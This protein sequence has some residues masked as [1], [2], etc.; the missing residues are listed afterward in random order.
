AGRHPIGCPQCPQPPS[1]GG[2]RP[3]PHLRC[4]RAHRRRA[5]LDAAVRPGLLAGRGAD[6]LRRDRRLR[7]L[8]RTA[9]GAVGLRRCRTGGRQ[10]HGRGRRL[11]RG[12]R[13]RAPADPG[14]RAGGGGRPAVRRRH[15]AGRVVGGDRRRGGDG[16]LHPLRGHRLRVAVPRRW[17]AGAHRDGRRPRAHPAL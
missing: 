17:T 10:P 9:G 15:G 5:R 8:P 7:R 1:T 16:A 12:H 6:G 11:R 14:H 13:Q 3:V 4:P 2:G